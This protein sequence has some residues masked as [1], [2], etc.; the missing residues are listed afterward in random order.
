MSDI[1]QNASGVIE[2]RMPADRLDLVLDQTRV[3]LEA[4]YDVTI[5]RVFNEEFVPPKLL[6]YVIDV[7]C[8]MNVVDEGTIKEE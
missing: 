5:E 2:L 8:E 6:Y 4:G 3:L 1:V 7:V